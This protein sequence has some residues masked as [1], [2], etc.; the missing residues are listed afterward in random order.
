M[1]NKKIFRLK[2]YVTHRSPAEILIFGFAAVILIGALLL[3]LPISSASGNS[4]GFLNAFF[5]ATSAVC[6]TGLVVVDT[7]TFWSL[8]GKLVIIT[9]IQIGGLGFMSLTTMFFVLAGKRITI[10]DRLLIQSSVNT[11][12]ISGIVKFIKY[13][14]FSSLVIE[15]V[16]ALFLSMV[17]IPEF[18]FGKGLAY[19]VFHAISAFCN[20]GFDL[21]GN[22]SSLTRYVD[23]FLVNFVIGGLIIFGGLGFAVTSD[24]LYIRKFNKMTMQAKLVLVITG[25]LLLFG[26]VLFFIFEFNN[27]RTMGNLSLNGK[28]LASFFQS[29]SPRTAGFNTIDMAALTKPS[30]FLTMLLMFVGASPGSTGGGV[31]TTTIGIIILTVASVLNGKKDVIAHKRTITGP[32]IR[33]AV[34]VVVIAMAIIIVMIFVLLCSEPDLSFESILFEVLSASGTVGLSMGITPHLSIS[35]KLALIVTMFV[36]RL[37]PLTVAYAISRNEK[38]LKE[39]IGSFKLPDGNIMIG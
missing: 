12:S 5:T 39:N 28:I 9:L 22:F 20:A 35:G 16:G 37:G 10:K 7:G 15:L 38:R 26:F 1:N 30:L 19:S 4:P 33:R 18:G 29:V 23:N 27:P 6:V 32:A 31:K 13:I 34:S 8:F 25:A 36:G 14:F 2:H 24:I 11:D 17:F 3:T 21:M